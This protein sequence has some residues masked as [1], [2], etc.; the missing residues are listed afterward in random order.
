MH[1]VVQSELYVDIVFVFFHIILG[2]GTAYAGAF[3]GGVRYVALST[4]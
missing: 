4:D 2:S 3:L 1:M